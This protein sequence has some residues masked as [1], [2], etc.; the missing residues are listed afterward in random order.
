M[1][2]FNT[3]EEQIMQILWKLKKGFPKE[4]LDDMKSPLP[5][6]TILSTI[7]K[8]EKDKFL[9]FN[10]FGKSHQY[11]PL[12]SKKDYSKS[13]YRSFFRDYLGSSKEQLLSFFMEEEDI[14][15]K[16]IQQLIKKL[17]K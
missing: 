13:I 5:Y 10:K 17:K 1:R 3:T 12:V 16:E 6:N 9:G 2:K 14:D 11:F 7:R 8:L 4:I 15:P